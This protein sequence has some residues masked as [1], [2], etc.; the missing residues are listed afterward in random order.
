MKSNQSQT[1]QAVS[2]ISNGIWAF[3]IALVL[4]FV[5]LSCGCNS[6]VEPS[7]KWGKRECTLACTDAGYEFSKK[8]NW[9][10][11]CG[12]KKNRLELEL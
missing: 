2:K 4:I 12:H 11:Y 5:V 7:R 10:C 1:R 9:K 6:K 3:A 8:N